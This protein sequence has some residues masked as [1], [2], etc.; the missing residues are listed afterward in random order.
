MRVIAEKIDQ[1]GAPLLRL[2]IHNAPHRR[3]HRATLQRYRQKLHE[4]VAKTGL[5]MPYAGPIELWVVMV[6]P[7]SPDLGNLYGAMERCFDGKAL[8]P[9]Y[10]L[11]DDGQIQVVRHLSKMFT[12]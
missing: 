12:G 6:N 3:S 9:P 5:K 10:I 11:D 1:A 2:Y 8:D 7:T 4:A